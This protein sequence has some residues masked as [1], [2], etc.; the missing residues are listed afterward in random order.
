MRVE[1]QAALHRRLVEQA[2]AVRQQ[3]GMHG[4]GFGDL[5]AFLA[6]DVVARHM[7]Q[8]DRDFYGLMSGG[9][10]P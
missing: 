8:A 5:V 4:L 2:R 9:T 10:E 1:E 6:M 7:L 3:A